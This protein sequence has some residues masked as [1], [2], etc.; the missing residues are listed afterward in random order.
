MRRHFVVRAVVALIAVALLFGAI[1]GAF[2][3][4]W[5]RGYQVGQVAES[6]EGATPYPWPRAIPLGPGH[7]SPWAYG[8][9]PFGLVRG[10]FTFVL[11]L[12]LFGLLTKAFGFWAWRKAWKTTGKDWRKA[13]AHSHVR[14]HPWHHGHSPHAP[15]GHC[16]PRWPH[17]PMPPWCWGEDEPEGGESPDEEPTEEQVGKVKPDAA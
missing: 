6:A 13:W 14:G 4:G 3:A 16:P 15:R 7:L 2:R 8:Y 10:L 17:G 9:R 5:W 1:G 11:L 12:F